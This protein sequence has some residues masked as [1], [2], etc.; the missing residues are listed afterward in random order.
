[1]SL[2][3]RLMSLPSQGLPQK[4]YS[5]ILLCVKSKDTDA[6]AKEAA[7]LLEEDGIMVSIQNGLNNWETIA[8]HVGE[9]RT[10]GARVIFGAEIP[11]PGLAG[12][13]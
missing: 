4:K 7:T 5:T 3:K 1:M 13:P 2:L 8:S 11:K 9:G 12:L 6:A 10:V